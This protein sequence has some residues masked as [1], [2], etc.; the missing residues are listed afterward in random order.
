MDKFENYG[1]RLET[2]PST[3]QEQYDNIKGVIC[4]ICFHIEEKI[5]GVQIKSLTIAFPLQKDNAHIT[6]NICNNH[7]R[8]AVFKNGKLYD[9]FPID[10]FALFD[11][12]RASGIYTRR[13]EN[14]IDMFGKGKLTQSQLAKGEI[15]VAWRQ[16]LLKEKIVAL[17][18]ES[19]DAT[20]Y[21]KAFYGQ[22]RDLSGDI[23][24]ISRNTGFSKEQIATVKEYV[25]QKEPDFLIAH[26][27]QRLM[28]KKD[29]I[30]P[31]DIT[32]LKNK[33]CELDFLSRG[34]S[35]TEA[36]N[37]ANAMYD[38]QWESNGFYGLQKQQKQ[39]VHKYE[40]KND[41]MDIDYIR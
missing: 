14:L 32:M 41:S 31:H 17:M 2:E 38:Y 5:K 24:Q 19:E 12:E 18:P 30:V 27:W 28:G 16:L 11:F 35:E 22:I 34:F 13:C 36:K 39:A 26:S 25:F 40:E 1:F 15:V 37:N 21:A 7:I 23:A 6:I 9:S 33:L 3:K 4:D 10:C 8:F 20:K 29:N